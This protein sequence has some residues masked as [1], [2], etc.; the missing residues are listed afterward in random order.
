MNSFTPQDFQEWV[1]RRQ[2]SVSTSTVSSA[3][4]SVLFSSPT[5]SP[6]SSSRKQSWQFYDDVVR[7]VL[8]PSVQISFVK[9]GQLFKLHYTF[10]DVCKDST[11][12]LRCLELGGGLG[13]QSPF[14]HG[15]SNTKLPVPHLEHPKSGDD[16]PL[17]VSFMDQ[18]TVHTAHTV[19]LTQLSYKFENWDDCVRFQELLL[20]SKLMFIGGMAEAKSKGRGEECISQ[21]LR[22]LRGHNGKRVILYFAN[23]Q[24]RE[25]KRYVSIPLNCIGGIKPP[26]KPGRPATVELNPNFEILAQMRNLTIQFL[27]D[28]GQCTFEFRRGSFAHQY[29]SSLDCKEF[30]QMLS[31]DLALG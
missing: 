18:Q 8:T 17:R 14:V 30:C 9:N 24:R 6:G 5:T 21:N 28:E 10:I 7:L 23:S 25:L 3:S 13:Q 1:D 29:I 19:F 20:C 22:I 4:T 2:S 16:Y 12:A 27:D 15:F 11:G 31:Y 26:K